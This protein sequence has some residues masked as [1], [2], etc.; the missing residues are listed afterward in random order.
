[1]LFTTIR[2]VIATLGLAYL[3]AFATNWW[4]WNPTQT[5]GLKEA[6]ANDMGSNWATAGWAIIALVIMVW[7]VMDKRRWT[8]VIGYLALGLALFSGVFTIRGVT[9][10]YGLTVRM[11]VVV[12][13]GVGLFLVA[14][15]P[16]KPEFRHVERYGWVTKS[17]DRRT[18]AAGQPSRV[19][20]A[21]NRANAWG[22]GL[23]RRFRNWREDRRFDR[24][25]RRAERAAAV[26]PPPPPD[27][28][29]H[30]V[31]GTPTATSSRPSRPAPVSASPVVDHSSTPAAPASGTTTSA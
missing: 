27:A 1:M 2:R 13:L 19:Q 7:G 9:A 18:L 10:D 26:P 20:R 23:E 16:S 30:P 21:A 17:G 8:T 12:L 6:F 25:Q 29:D 4:A 5:A 28:D 3:V 31:F 14:I 11:V 15:W 22:L 24:E